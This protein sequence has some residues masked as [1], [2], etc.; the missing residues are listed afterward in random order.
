MVMSMTHVLLLRRVVQPGLFR[1]SGNRE[2]KRNEA[3]TSSKCCLF[4]DM[5]LP[6]SEAEASARMREKTYKS[7]VRSV[8]RLLE[9]AEPPQ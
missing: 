7:E 5:H 1:I 4:D 6:L 2:S 8:T 3:D 9:T